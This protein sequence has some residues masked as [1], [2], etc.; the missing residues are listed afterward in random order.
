MMTGR[1][2]AELRSEPAA[3]KVDLPGSGE[4]EAGEHTIVL[5]KEGYFG[6]AEPKS[7]EEAQLILDGKLQREHNEEGLMRA[8]GD[9]AAA[10]QM[11]RRALE[12]PARQPAYQLPPK[13]ESLD[14]D[15]LAA[16]IDKQVARDETVRWNR[17]EVDRSAVLE[18]SAGKAA[19]EEVPGLDDGP[20]GG[21]L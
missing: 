17:R 1:D 8:R 14:G 11:K 12:S 21:G 7:S 2:A 18:P 9:L 10:E 6:P 3:A 19:L 13:G 4:I 15:E 5:E 16:N 20:R